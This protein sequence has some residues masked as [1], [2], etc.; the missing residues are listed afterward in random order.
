MGQSGLSIFNHS[1]ANENASQIYKGLD[2]LPREVRFKL[3]VFPCVPDFIPRGLQGAF[4][5]RPV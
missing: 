4:D 1:K 3:S 5:L 2:F